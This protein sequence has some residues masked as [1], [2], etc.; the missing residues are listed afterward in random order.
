MPILCPLTVG[1][2]REANCFP[3]RLTHR[4]WSRSARLIERADN[5][6]GYG[7][8]ND[9]TDTPGNEDGRGQRLN[10]IHN[11]VSPARQQTKQDPVS[12]SARNAAAAA[13]AADKNHGKEKS[14]H[15]LSK[16]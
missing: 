2:R 16:H 12:K 4:R 7:E 13:E 3:Y 6:P 1:G 10:C 15:A 8:L 5:C 11:Q 14:D 9:Y